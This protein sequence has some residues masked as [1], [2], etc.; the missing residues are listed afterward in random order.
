M[1]VALQPV[2][3]TEPVAHYQGPVLRH[4]GEERKRPVVIHAPVDV[5]RGEPIEERVLPWH[6]RRRVVHGRL[7]R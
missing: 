7:A 6:E 5:P 2:E 4:D 1:Q 3:P